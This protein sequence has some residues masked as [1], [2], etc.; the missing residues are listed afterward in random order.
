MRFA[1]WITKVKHARTRSRATHTQRICDTLLF[2]CN[3]GCTNSPHCCLL[4][5]LS[6]WRV[7][8][9][10]WAWPLMMRT[11]S[12]SGYRRARSLPATEGTLVW[13][14]LTGL[15]YH[16]HTVTSTWKYKRPECV[17][18]WHRSYIAV[19]RKLRTFISQEF[20]KLLF[21][22][23]LINCRCINCTLLSSGLVM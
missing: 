9:M 17:N 22:W 6:Y 20:R 19:T 11:A 16:C 12:A 13:F 23:R 1:C 21:K 5:T 3:N 10:D 14:L 18:A 2:H 15:H 7:S 4:R 8:A